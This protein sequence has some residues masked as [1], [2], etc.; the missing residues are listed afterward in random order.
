MT[1]NDQFVSG[2]PVLRCLVC[3]FVALEQQSVV[4]APG[5]GSHHHDY[6][7]KSI[8]QVLLL[9]STTAVLAA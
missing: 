2:E 8:E 4:A 1:T 5:Y 3:H 7:S 9:Q 6:L